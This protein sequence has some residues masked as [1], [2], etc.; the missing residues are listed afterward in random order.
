[1]GDTTFYD[2]VGALASAP[3][4]LLTLNAEPSTGNARRRTAAIT[5][6]GRDV[7]VG[8]RDAVALNGID[9]WRGGVHLEAL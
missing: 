1:M 3:V 4:P 5:T 7:L 8:R 6:A 9:L 2:I